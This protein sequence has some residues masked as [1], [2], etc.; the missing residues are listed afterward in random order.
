VLAKERA[1][2]AD[3]VDKRRPRG[4]PKTVDDDARR[5][6]IVREARATFYE[7][8]YGGTTMDLVAARCRISKQTL[9]KLFPSKTDLFMAIITEHRASMLALP[10]PADENLP[11]DKALEQIF[12]IDIKEDEERERDAFIHLAISESQRF[13][14]IATLL[15]TYGAK[16]SQQLL[17][18]WLAE[19][20][21]AGVIDIGDAASGARML[22]DM[23]FGAM[24]SRP[25]H[26]SDWP[27]R[28]TRLRHLRRCIAIFTAGARPRKGD[29]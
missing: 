15:H 19:Q 3:Q 10:R 11:F 24:V 20:Q 16:P 14:E 8:G 1:V 29:G 26:P 2:K 22:M 21:E 12:M 4:R 6:E 23:I 13:P 18:D 5:A 9:Y 25:G 17:A 28:E 27:D 7:L